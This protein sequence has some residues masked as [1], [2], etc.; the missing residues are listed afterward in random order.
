MAV[1]I[2]DGDQNG[3]QLSL[4]NALGRYLAKLFLCIFTLTIS[5]MWAGWDERKQALHDKVAATFVFYSK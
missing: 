1:G 5:L 2:K 3:E 4:G